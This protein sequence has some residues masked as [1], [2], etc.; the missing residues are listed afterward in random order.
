MGRP[1]SLELRERVIAAV[2]Q[3]GLPPGGGA[4]WSGRQCGHS[5]G[6]ALPSDGQHCT[7][8]DGWAQAEGDFAWLLERTKA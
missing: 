4:I 8:P 1:Y 3:G 6:A 7:G 2:D 5:L